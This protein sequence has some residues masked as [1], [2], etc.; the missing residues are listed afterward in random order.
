MFPIGASSPEISRMLL[1]P[2]PFNLP[3]VKVLCVAFF[4]E[5]DWGLGQ[6][7][8]VL[9]FS[10]GLDLFFRSCLGLW[11]FAHSKLNR[12]EILLSPAFR[13]STIEHPDNSP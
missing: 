13:L 4:Q 10:L 7:P 12:E 2:Q 3:P 1:F 8:K 9:T 11:V 6:R 5:S